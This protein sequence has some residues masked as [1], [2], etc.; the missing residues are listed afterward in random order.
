[1][2]CIG[3]VRRTKRQ[4]FKDVST[5]T[6]TNL[7]RCKYHRHADMLI[8]MP[9]NALQTRRAV[10]K[11]VEACVWMIVHESD[12]QQTMN[13]FHETGTKEIER[14]CEVTCRLAWAAWFVFLP[15]FTSHIMQA[16]WFP[17]VLPTYYP[18]ALGGGPIPL[19]T[20]QAPNMCQLFKTQMWH[21][22]VLAPQVPNMFQLSK[23]QTCANS[24]SSKGVPAV[25]D[26]EQFTRN[27]T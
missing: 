26:H 19:E 12:G 16:S 8:L 6:N 5:A 18:I 3:V 27:D 13:M 25:D 20:L 9:S 10:W 2:G 24:V 7:A 17:P 15:S 4:M 1:M 23:I 14:N 22:R 11:N 21:T